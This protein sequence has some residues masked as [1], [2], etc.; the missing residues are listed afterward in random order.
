MLVV[1]QVKLGKTA[2]A[3]AKAGNVA[4]AA[5]NANGVVNQFR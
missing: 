3:V 4:G 2:T 5:A 1:T